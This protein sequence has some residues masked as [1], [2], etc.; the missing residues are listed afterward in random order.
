M[1]GMVDGQTGRSGQS[2]RLCVGEACN[3]EIE[4]VMIQVQQALEQTVMDIREKEENVTPSGNVMVKYF[5]KIKFSYQNG[6]GHNA[7][8]FFPKLKPKTKCH[9]KN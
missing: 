7:I 4:P 1:I 6:L 8:T 9:F 3:G 5:Y 2:A